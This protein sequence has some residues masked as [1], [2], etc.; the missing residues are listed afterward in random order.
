MRIGMVGLAALYWPV[1]I[2]RGIRAEDARA[3]VAAATLGVD[4]RTIEKTLGMPPQTYAARFGVN[5]Y[6][7]ANDMIDCEDLDTVVL[8]TRHTEHAEWAERMAALGMDIVIPKTFAT[9]MGDADRIVAA[10][11]RHGV[12]IAVGPSARFLPALIAIRKIVE[13]GEIGEPFSLRICHHHGTIDGFHADDWY[14]DPAEGGPELS[15]GWYGVDL[16]RHLMDDEVNEVYAEYGNYT[17]PD[18]PFMD[19]GRMVCRM[20]RGGVASFD[21]YFCN[22]VSYPSWQ[23]EI[24]GPAGVASIHRIPGDSRGFVVAVDDADGYRTVELPT[25]TPNW[26]TFWLEDLRDGREPTIDAEAA[27]RI[28]EISIAARDS[29]ASGGPVAV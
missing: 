16:I 4:E 14:R 18:S 7:S 5:L 24:V 10:G 9:R 15:L 22:R 26:E 19:C 28:T 12:R 1:A 20:G 29:A 3:L 27:R 13:R 8:I 25:D 2:G 6:E 17:T 23:L 11:R 21:M